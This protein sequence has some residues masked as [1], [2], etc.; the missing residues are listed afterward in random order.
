MS[1]AELARVGTA[2]LGAVA[3]LG[4]GGCR[5]P[6]LADQE[7]VGAASG[8]VM[9]SLDESL[10]GRATTAFLTPEPLRGPL[11][12]RALDA[13]EPSAYAASCFP[14]TFSACAAGVRTRQYTQCSLGPSTL[15]GTVTLTFTRT[16]LCALATADDAVTRTADLTLT[17]PWGGTLTVSSPDGGQTL[18][19]T[20]AGFEFTVAGMERVLVGPGGRT[21]FDISTRTTAPF[22]VTGS[23][24]ADLVIASGTLEVTHELAGYTVS[25][26]ASNLAWS[27]TCN[28]AVSGSLTG[29]VTSGK[30]SGRSATVELKGCG[31]ADVT[32]DGDT[33]SVTL[34]RCAGI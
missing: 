12:R 24:R 3:V 15:D 31:R 14:S 4:A 9:A 16:A 19:K 1:K 23:S 20:A 21:L 13:L 34:D 17:G 10:D 28:C 6:S 29:T 26:D 25:L 30:L 11:W 32:I 8:E 27:A 18:T 33:D 22:V 2:V 7:Q 5:K